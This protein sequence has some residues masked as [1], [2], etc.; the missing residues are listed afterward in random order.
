MHL[1]HKLEIEK[2]YDQAQRALLRAEPGLPRSRVSSEAVRQLEVRR[3]LLRAEP[4]LPRSRRVARARQYGSWRIHKRLSTANSNTKQ[5][6]DDAHP[7]AA[8]ENLVEG[9]ELFKASG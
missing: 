5:K 9:S 3:A 8:E 1:S 7:E 4:G 6:K 2:C